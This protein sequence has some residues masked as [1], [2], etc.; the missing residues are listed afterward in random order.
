VPNRTWIHLCKQP[1]W[2][3]RHMPTPQRY[4]HI[5]THAT[6]PPPHT[7][8]S[9][10]AN[11]EAQ[12]VCSIIYYM[13]IHIHIHYLVRPVTQSEIRKKNHHRTPGHLLQKKNNQNGHR[14]TERHRQRQRQT[15][16][17]RERESRMYT[18]SRPVTAPLPQFPSFHSL[19]K[20]HGGLAR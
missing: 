5:L 9:R 18:C 19:R 16:R 15:E 6:L 13:H 4:N 11:A 12:A 8:R 3:G 17:D 10:Q 14:L 7:R 2:M 20:R 1:T